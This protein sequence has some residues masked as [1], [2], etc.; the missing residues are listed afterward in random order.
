MAALRSL[1]LVLAFLTAIHAA[2]IDSGRPRAALVALASSDNIDGMVSSMHDV[3]V[4]FNNNHEY[5]WCFFSTAELSIAFKE[6]VSNATPASRYDFDFKFDPFRAMRDGNRI[7]GRNNV[8]LGDSHADQSLYQTTT[9]FMRENPT[10]VEPTADI[11]WVLGPKK[12]ELLKQYAL[13]PSESTRSTSSEAEGSGG[14]DDSL[15]PELDSLDFDMPSKKYVKAPFDQALSAICKHCC[16]SAAIEMGSL[17]FF[18]SPAF[19]RFFN[20]L[21]AHG[22]FY[23]HHLAASPV[24]PLSAALFAPDAVWLLDDEASCRAGTTAVY[25]TPPPVDPSREVP[26]LAALIGGDHFGWDAGYLAGLEDYSA[27]WRQYW[28]LVARDF[29]RQAVRPRPHQGFTHNGDTSKEGLTFLNET[30]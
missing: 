7:Y 5:D 11:S 12:D 19:A 14:K 27:L 25:D 4:G 2:C 21:D 16:P 3:E 26:F 23:Y 9:Q 28:D 20:H 22:A 18:G 13:A 15:R 24:S 10:I 8:G 6:A 1:V 17:A 30:V 29:N